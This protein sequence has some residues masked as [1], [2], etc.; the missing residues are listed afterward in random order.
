[1]SLGAAYQNPTVSICSGGFAWIPSTPP[2]IGGINALKGYD[3]LVIHRGAFRNYYVNQNGKSSVLANAASKFLGDPYSPIY[4][5]TR[6][7]T[8]VNQSLK[9][10]TGNNYV[11][12]N[13]T[14]FIQYTFPSS[15]QN[16]R[17]SCVQ[18]EYDLSFLSGDSSFSLNGFSSVSAATVYGVLSNG[19][20]IGIGTIGITRART[21]ST[22][23]NIVYFNGV[24]DTAVFNTI[25]LKTATDEINR[26]S[27][28]IL[29]GVYVE[30]NY[31]NSSLVFA[32]KKI[33]FFTADRVNFRFDSDQKQLPCSALGY[34]FAINGQF[35]PTASYVSTIDV[36]SGTIGFSG[37]T[38]SSGAFTWPS[39]DRTIGCNVHVK[40]FSPDYITNSPGF[41]HS[42][43]LHLLILSF[44]IVAGGDTIQSGQEYF[45][46]IVGP[47]PFWQ[48]MVFTG[49][50]VPNNKGI[51]TVNTLVAK[52]QKQQGTYNV[53]ENGNNL[54]QQFTINALKSILSGSQNTSYEFIATGIGASTTFKN[55]YVDTYGIITQSDSYSSQPA[56]LQTYL[57]ASDSS[58][59]YSSNGS[60]SFSSSSP[61]SSPSKVYTY[62]SYISYITPTLDSIFSN[63]NVQPCLIFQLQSV[64]GYGGTVY[65]Q[66]GFYSAVINAFKTD[67]A[68]IFDTKLIFRVYALPNNSS[69]KNYDPNSAFALQHHLKIIPNSSG[70]PSL[71]FTKYDNSWDFTNVLVSGNLETTEQ[72]IYSEIQINK[73]SGGFQISSDSFLLY[74][75]V[76]SVSQVNDSIKNI[77]FNNLSSFNLP[78]VNFVI[79]SDFVLSL[80]IYYPRSFVNGGYIQPEKDFGY[81]GSYTNDTNTYV[82]TNLFENGDTFDSTQPYTSTFDSISNFS[83]LLTLTYQPFSGKAGFFTNII[84]GSTQNPAITEVDFFVQTPLLNNAL[85]KS[86]NWDIVLSFDSSSLSNCLVKIEIDLIDTITNEYIL[87]IL[88]SPY[89]DVSSDNISCNI[90][91]PFSLTPSVTGLVLRVFFKNSAKTSKITFTNI[92][93]TSTTLNFFNYIKTVLPAGVQVGFYEDLPLQPSSFIGGCN[94]FLLI[95][96]LPSSGSIIFQAADG[97]FINGAVYS[98]TWL[99]QLPDNMQ[100]QFKSDIGGSN[101][102]T[103]ILPYSIYF[104]TGVSGKVQSVDTK[105]HGIT[106]NVITVT[107]SPSSTSD[108]NVRQFTTQGS[109][110]L[111][112]QST[113]MLTPSSTYG[114]NKLEVQFPVLAKTQDLI[115][116]GQ[117]SVYVNTSSILYENIDPSYYSEQP[118]PQGTMLTTDIQSNINLALQIANFVATDSEK[119]KY[120]IVG[121]TPN[122]NLLYSENYT[123]S[124]TKANPVYLVE[125]KA[126]TP[127]LTSVNITI[128]N[129]LNG[130]VNAYFPGF[131]RKNGSSLVFYTYKTGSNLNL[132]TSIYMQDLDL[133]PGSP[134]LVFNFNK[135][136][137]NAPNINNITVCKYDVYPNQTEFQI[138]FDCGNKLFT[139]K[140]Y[141]QPYKVFVSGLTIIYGNLGTNASNQK[142]VADLNIM[143]SKGQL[144]TLNTNNISTFYSNDLNNSQKVGFVDYDGIYLGVQF[145]IGTAVQEILFDVH[146]SLPAKYRLVGAI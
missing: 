115:V 86:G 103:G 88:S 85:V 36:S 49:T 75:A 142:F 121:I 20:K 87:K 70:G 138:V 128:N 119:N 42:F 146:Y 39:N 13:S 69:V 144:Q 141:Y 55:Y 92:K 112:T 65:V 50:S 72:T 96:D 135:Y 30:S 21:S 52:T 67:I 33:M 26:N 41:A 18:L 106:K 122:G 53:Y 132:N 57:N 7:L 17:L 59:N 89:Q 31:P 19:N 137:A 14:Q 27:Y 126:N 43:N 139:L 60:G 116:I 129:K 95:L 2:N 38:D 68:N 84:A 37:S 130:L 61:N 140:V 100:V 134:M 98:P 111:S 8:I 124:M 28:P 104:R 125:G 145:I 74:V 22:E 82:L 110:R 114:L 78:L 118:S 32:L 10:A 83:Q 133:A 58:L 80:P 66:P 5:S 62:Q 91:I 29:K 90:N 123:N 120:Y 117:K 76:Y 15:D 24:N 44:P 1:M 71:Q 54:N 136:T 81:T 97:I 93:I 6:P 51:V 131:I 102:P 77:N 143:I 47:K 40:V 56:R 99:D 16:L 23:N 108:F 34:S 94:N 63:P 105:K 73:N 4:N 48:Q 3:S 107:N 12:Y 25:S 45:G 11:A 64:Y 127:E 113:L 9:P 79:N 109:S 35:Y 101:F 46:V